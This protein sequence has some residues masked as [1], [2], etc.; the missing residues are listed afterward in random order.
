[1]RTQSKRSATHAALKKTGD[2]FKTS[3]KLPMSR[4]AQAAVE[5]SKLAARRKTTWNIESLE[6]RVLLSADAV[7]GVHRLEGAIDQPGEQ[8]TYQFVIT[9][10]T[11]ML[12]DGVQGSPITWQ[13]QG[14]SAST[15]F[16]SKDIAGGANPFLEL[17]P[18]TYQLT[19]QAASDY[20]GTYVFR[21]FGEESAPRLALNTPITGELPSGQQAALYAVEVQ[22]GDRLYFQNN[23]PNTKINWSLYD[24]NAYQVVGSRSMGSDWGGITAKESGTYWLSIEGQPGGTSPASYGFTLFQ[25]HRPQAQALTLGQIT[26][27]LLDQ[28]G[29]AAVYQFD[30]TQGDWVCFDN[31]PNT[32]TSGSMQW[33][34]QDPQGQVIASGSSSSW[35]NPVAVQTG[36]YTLT[37]SYSG[38]TTGPLHFRVVSTHQAATLPADVWLNLGS[39]AETG[40]YRLSNDAAAHLSLATAFAVGAP[41]GY[42]LEYRITD[43]QGNNVAN[44]SLGNQSGAKIDFPFPG[45]YYLWLRWKAAS[46]QGVGSQLRVS[47]WTDQSQSMGEISSTAAQNFSATLISG[48]TVNMAFD[49]AT[50]GLWTWTAPTA[51]NGLWWS[52][53]G[54]FGTVHS[55]YLSNALNGN[56]PA[57]YL[58]QGHYILTV[59]ASSGVGGSFNLQATPADLSNHLAADAATQF[60]S[61]SVGQ[62]AWWKLDSQAGDRYE[63]RTSTNL[64]GYTARFFDAYGKIINAAHYSDHILSNV[65]PATGAVYLQLVRN[66]SQGLSN[67]GFLTL[68]T[69]HDNPIQQDPGQSIELGTVV[70]GVSIDLLDPHYVFDLSK[71]GM[72]FMEWNAEAASSSYRVY[73]PAGEEASGY[74]YAGNTIDQLGTSYSWPMVIPW[75]A[76]GRHR[77]HFDP[78]ESGFG[79]TLHSSAEAELIASDTQVRRTLAPEQKLVLFALDLTSGRDYQFTGLAEAGGGNGFALYDAWGQAVLIGDPAADTSVRFSPH[80]NGRYTLAIYRGIEADSGS[81]EL[82][83]SV[84]SQAHVAD[85]TQEL[86]TISTTQH[87]EPSLVAAGQQAIYTFDVAQSGLWMLD[88]GSTEFAQALWTLESADGH[89]HAYGD[90]S[91]STYYLAPGVNAGRDWGMYESA[92]LGNYAGIHYLSAGHYTLTLG[93]TDD[94]TGSLALTLRP[95]DSAVEIAANATTPLGSVAPGDSV[96]LRLPVTALDSF[97]LNLGDLQ[98]EYTIK[99]WDV[100]GRALGNMEWAD[101]DWFWSTGLAGEVAYIWLVRQTHT[102]DGAEA[103]A[104]DAILTLQTSVTE[105]DPDLNLP[106]VSWGQVIETEA[107]YGGENHYRVN[108]DAPGLLFVDQLTNYDGINVYGQGPNSLEGLD[109]IGSDYFYLG[110]ETGFAWMRPVAVTAGWYDLTVTNWSENGTRWRVLSSADAPALPL[111]SPVQVSMGNDENI[112]LYGVDLQA[113]EALDL[114]FESVSGWGDFYALLDASG[115]VVSAGVLAYLG[116]T[117]P[118]PVGVTGHYTLLLGRHSE[119]GDARGEGVFNFTAKIVPAQSADE[120]DWGVLDVSGASASLS[121]QPGEYKSIHFVVTDPSGWIIESPH[122]TNSIYFD[123]IEANGGWSKSDYFGNLHTQGYPVFLMPGDYTLWISQQGET[124]SSVDLQWVSMAQAQTIQAGDPI[125]LNVVDFQ[126]SALVAIQVEAGHWVNLLTDGGPLTDFQVE[127]LDSYARVLMVPE[128][129]DAAWSY[130][131][132]QS[133]LLYARFVRVAD[134]GVVLPNVRFDLTVGELLTTDAQTIDLNTPIQWVPSAGLGFEFEVTHD[135]WVSLNW[136][137]GNWARY[138]LAGPSGVVADGLIQQNFGYY[139]ASGGAYQSGIWSAPV[140][141]LPAG[142]YQLRLTEGSGLAKFMLA[143]ATLAQP[144]TLNAP[145]SQTLATDSSYALF[146]VVLDPTHNNY[147]RGLSGA[148]SHMVWRLFDGRGQVVD[149]GNPADTSAQLLHPTYSGHYLLMVAN[150]TQGVAGDRRMNFE[151]DSVPRQA[152]LVNVGDT[153]DGVFIASNQAQDYRF[154]VEEATQLHIH[155]LASN[156]SPKTY[157]LLDSRGYSVNTLS[158]GQAY[159]LAAGGYTLRVQRTQTSVPAAGDSFSVALVADTASHT[160]A[161]GE[162]AELSF[163]TGTADTTLKL[164][165]HAGQGYWLGVPSTMAYTDGYYIRVFDPTGRQVIST[166]FGGTWFS[167]LPG[168]QINAQFT[169]SYTVMLSAVTNYYSAY[170]GSRTL[171]LRQLQTSQIDYQPGTEVLGSLANNMDEVH[172]RFTVTEQ[173]PFWL[174]VDQDNYSVSL[175][176]VDA[177]G[178]VFTNRTSDTNQVTPLVAGTYELVVRANSEAPGSYRIKLSAAK[179]LP[180]FTVGDSISDTVEVNTWGSAWQVSA[181]AGQS[182]LISAKLTSGDSLR[183]YLADEQGTT[184]AYGYGYNSAYDYSVRV[185]LPTNGPEIGRYVLYCY[186]FYDYPTPRNSLIQISRYQEPVS[187]IALGDQVNGSLA[188]A[189]DIHHYTFTLNEARTL[190]V[191]PQGGSAT[192]RLT[193]PSGTVLSLALDSDTDYWIQRLAP[194]SYSLD[195]EAEDQRTTPAYAFKLGELQDMAVAHG[196]STQLSGDLPAGRTVVVHSFD[197]LQGH[198]YNLDFTEPVSSNYYFRYSLVDAAGRTLSHLNWTNS[199]SIS[200]TAADSGAMYLVAKQYYASPTAVHFEATLREPLSSATPLVWDG[201]NTTELRTYVDQRDFEFDLSQPTWI[202]LHNLQVSV[203]QTYLEIIAADGSRLYSRWLYASSNGA[204]YSYQ[205]GAGHYAIRLSHQTDG[206]QGIVSFTARQVPQLQQL[207]HQP[208]VTRTLSQEAGTDTV[209]LWSLAIGAGEH[210]ELRADTWSGSG[211]VQLLHPSGSVLNTWNPAAGA[212]NINIAAGG[213]Y[214]LRVMRDSLDHVPSNA[215]RFQASWGEAVTGDHT[216]TSTLSANGTIQGN[217]TQQFALQVLTDGAWYLDRHMPPDSNSYYSG[218]SVTVTNALGVTVCSNWDQTLWLQAGVY[219]VTLKASSVTTHYGFS[220]LALDGSGTTSLTYGQSVTGSSA[221]PHGA[222]VYAIDVAAQDVIQLNALGTSGSPTPSYQL[223]NAFGQPLTSWSRIS[224]DSSPITLATTGKVYVVL[225]PSIGSSYGYTS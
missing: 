69:L 35:P 185:P 176:R 156:G 100:D 15:S 103:A 150:N 155:P 121:L 160:L 66:S 222:Q 48:Q 78:V 117:Q 24:I 81:P 221:T 68:T 88:L 200:F 132:E 91:S 125:D 134:S 130:Q 7:P 50:S 179:D 25:Q 28:P 84:T 175:N 96:L 82:D 71:S 74:A 40:V 108:V 173:A 168:L 129:L 57:L 89:H 210:L 219:T 208:G 20:T 163:S 183:W 170:T 133:G 152:Q 110:N 3:I 32:G 11:R 104:A 85:L 99:I 124:T 18:G 204:A 53:D 75:L 49:V 119:Y 148:G 196:T 14:P 180:V 107:E 86:G 114:A 21:L 22:A 116:Q 225:D 135:G 98:N 54:P 26:T 106:T 187:A 203:N 111:N 127:L 44:S 80:H 63:L 56:G 142:H 58:S 214:L 9:E 158:P 217:S 194:G 33:Q 143:D 42:P 31:A 207:D 223:L 149:T 192:L 195:V 216:P 112:Q 37:L 70:E 19:V 167:S 220:W 157:T 23:L 38:R 76:G 197:V 186:S 17:S 113:G 159:A 177:A 206:T 224:S 72:V 55:D 205:L 8:D 6:P 13:L 12:F 211:S 188:A 87:I 1:M 172:Y 212:L 161:A 5:M 101:R 189:G 79:F 139:P 136:E 145:F 43:L 154:V 77:L 199:S 10:N 128:N 126:G 46:N 169:G 166:D 102:R 164:D 90:T 153:I 29:S 67:L 62:A 174:H 184:V 83:F 95:L 193:G 51:A 191:D 97:Q 41:S 165:L 61:F 120:L 138:Q 171:H 92:I 201:V 198:S 190:L 73:G 30:A 146:D 202:E 118:A 64:S 140:V 16:S 34:L 147:L 123:L 131:A 65:N 105:L 151:L 181:A 93:L 27:A 59:Q 4:M 209:S 182:L 122:E 218:A 215:Y 36:R 2:Q 47:A 213:I 109:W 141:W 144:L 115:N 94:Q 178:T 162:D 137:Q 60:P 52:L 39:N 45:E